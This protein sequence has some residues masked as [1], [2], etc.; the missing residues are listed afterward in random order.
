[1]FT[2]VRRPYPSTAPSVT[3]MSKDPNG[4]V[5]PPIV[6]K[7]IAF[8]DSTLSAESEEL[9][10]RFFKKYSRCRAHT[11]VKSW[12]KRPSVPKDETKT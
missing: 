6:L 12:L 11:G 2:N 8:F 3:L 5:V 7:E 4:T 9:E 10:M 1:V